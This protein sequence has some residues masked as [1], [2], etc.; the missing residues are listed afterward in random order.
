VQGLAANY[1]QG[2]LDSLSAQRSGQL[3]EQGVRENDG[4]RLLTE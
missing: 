2:H 3:F 4:Y 1:A